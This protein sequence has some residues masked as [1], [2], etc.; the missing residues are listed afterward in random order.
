MAQRFRIAFPRSLQ[1]GLFM[2]RCHID[3]DPFEPLRYN[4]KQ[5]LQVVTGTLNLTTVIPVLNLIAHDVFILLLAP[6]TSKEFIFRMSR[7]AGETFCSRVLL[8]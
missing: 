6:S 7:T 3:D 2:K 5:I 1:K 4:C 8:S